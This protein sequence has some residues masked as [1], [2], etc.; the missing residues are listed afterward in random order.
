ML[1]ITELSKKADILK[2]YIKETKD[3]LLKEEYNVKSIQDANEKIQAQIEQSKKR[4][5]Q[6]EESRKQKI[7]D[8]NIV[9]AELNNIDIV[10]EIEKH[11][12]LEI[13]K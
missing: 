4:S 12:Q 3:D 5:E 10:T 7:A 8:Y 1:G 13:L 2:E 6:W 11:K 9:L